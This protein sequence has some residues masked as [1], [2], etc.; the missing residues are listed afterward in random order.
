MNVTAHELV[1]HLLSDEGGW[2]QEALANR[3]G[4]SQSTINR[5]FNNPKHEASESVYRALMRVRP[6]RRKARKPK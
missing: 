3:V 1:K 4:V 2:Q 5:I 6:V